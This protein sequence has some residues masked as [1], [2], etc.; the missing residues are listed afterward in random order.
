MLI[1]RLFQTVLISGVMTL[2]VPAVAATDSALPLCGES[3]DHADKGETKKNDK[4]QG[5]ETAEENEKDDK[6]KETK[7]EGDA[8]A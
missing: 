7:D 8:P 6:K 4:K 3:K 2:V 5:T 1:Q